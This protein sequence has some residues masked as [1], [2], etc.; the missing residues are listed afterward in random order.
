MKLKLVE[1]FLGQLNTIETH[2]G[3]WRVN[4]DRAVRLHVHHHLL[5]NI[6]VAHHLKNKLFQIIYYYLIYNVHLFI[7]YW[8]KMVCL[9][10]QILEDDNKAYFLTKRF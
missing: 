7:G 8:F 5:V 1:V 9:A 4:T 2:A 3:W 10:Q 6:C